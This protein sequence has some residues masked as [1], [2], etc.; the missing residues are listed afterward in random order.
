M[1]TR[2]AILGPQLRRSPL[3]MVAGVVMV[4]A[5][6]LTSAG[7]YGHLNHSQDVI[8]IIAPVQR[9]EA[10]P[11]TALRVVQMNGDPL[12]KPLSASHLEE[13]V[14]K[15]ATANLNPGDYLTGADFGDRLG[16]VLGQ[17]EIG[18]ALAVGHYPDGIMRPGDRVLLV[19]IDRMNT[20]GT[21]PPATYRAILASIGAPGQS[22][23]IT[24]TVI[25]STDDA[26]L[27]AQLAAN[28][29]LAMILLADH[30]E[31]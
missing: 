16:P 15:Y 4:I 10:I 31:G 23:V 17:A 12:L 13:V 5:G 8:A 22:G 11:S 26:G 27:V 18:I 6:A 3:L 29:R 28:N 20:A 2:P 14:G 1:S 24:T 7:I 19:S 30:E 25:V 21:A 9:G